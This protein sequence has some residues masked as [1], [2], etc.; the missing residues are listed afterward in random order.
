MSRIN[1]EI[2][3]LRSLNGILKETWEK[4]LSLPFQLKY[5]SLKMIEQSGINNLVYYYLLFHDKTYELARA[6]LFIAFTDFSSMDT[7]ILSDYRKRIKQIYPDFLNFKTLECANICLLGEGLMVK[8]DEDFESILE[9]TAREMDD[10]SNEEGVKIQVFRD[11]P[12]EKFDR[13]YQ[14]LKPIGFYPALGFP[15]AVMDVRWNSIEEYFSDLKKK[16]RAADYYKQSFRIKEKFG[17]EY[18]FIRDYK[19]YKNEL[20][21]L[22]KQV[23]DKASEYEREYF[24]PEFFESA[25]DMLRDSSEVLLMKYGDQ[26]VAFSFNIFDEH[27]YYTMYWGVDYNF[28]NYKNAH[29]YKANNIFS[30]SRAIELGKKKLEMGITAYDPKLVLGAVAQPLVYF[31]RHRDSSEYS[32]TMAHL[33]TDSI[34]QPDNFFHH[35]FKEDV[36]NRSNLIF[37][38]KEIKKLQL[39]YPDGDI[40]NKVSKYYK[41]N[42]ARL[43]GIYNYYPEFNTAQNSCVYL[44]DKKIVLLGTNSYL[45]A[46]SNPEVMNA[47]KEA[48]DQYGTGCSGSP[49]LNGT[50]DIHK[51]LENELAEFLGREAVV[52]CSTGY[53]TNLAGITA[54]CGSEDVIVLDERSHRSLFDA[55]KLSGATY[56][57]YRHNDMKN[58]E[59]VLSKL[60][61]RNVL[62]VTDSVFSMEGTIPD[63][64]AISELNKK[65]GSR[66]FVDEAHGIGVFG[67]NGRGACEAAGIEKD[68]DMIMGTF[69]KS[70]ASLGG[71]IA[72]D[73]RVIDHIKH[74]GSPHIFS[75]SLP[76]SVAA[77]VRAVLKLIKEKP[78]MR[79]DIM[80]KAKF[81]GDSL[82]AMGYN[83]RFLG[84]QIVPVILGNEILTLAAAKIFM[85][86]GVYVNPVLQPAVPEIATG[87]RTSYIATHDWDDLKAAL[88]I[89]EKY[90][91]ILGVSSNGK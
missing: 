3:K 41:A 90:K 51:K 58:L 16:N 7:S 22:W 35:P 66:L 63:L 33:I 30:L 89:F 39:D 67:A 48:I 72:G 23:Y 31:V 9:R 26:I 40:F 4:N 50:L 65:Y 79:K 62:L 17:I 1:I 64:K 80:D 11:V 76:A 42:M 18:E 91:H 20:S 43:S 10:I 55:A 13:Y 86:E 5:N 28:T 38:S 19:K 85:D 25:A 29:L 61:G 36:L 47:A 82:E 52:I 53:Q 81:M 14:T 27:T 60:P 56:F 49:L 78:G 88:K 24:T 75:A 83:A 44:E 73:F 71:F 87:F 21:S 59:K 46:A 12:Y 69:S 45:G 8:D 57:V 15:K 54:L 34:K 32:R 74:K 68:V 84:T 2:E 37:I 77:T 6:N 70:F